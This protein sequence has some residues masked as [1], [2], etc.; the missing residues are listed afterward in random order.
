VAQAQLKQNCHRPQR[1][2]L[3]GR[4]RQRGERACDRDDAAD[5]GRRARGEAAVV[6]N[7]REEAEIRAMLEDPGL[8]RIDL[9]NVKIAKKDVLLICW[10]NARR[11]SMICGRHKTEF[12]SLGLN[13]E[14][15]KKNIGR[16]DE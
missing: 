6:I 12:F 16:A 2:Q 7:G 9:M 4:G 10:E 13:D 15:T 5:G 8:D 3:P 11:R 1:L 14:K